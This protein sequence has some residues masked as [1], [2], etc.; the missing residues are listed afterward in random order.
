M[1]DNDYMICYYMYIC[2]LYTYTETK[3]LVML[4]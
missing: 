3:T 4:D 1:N 2:V